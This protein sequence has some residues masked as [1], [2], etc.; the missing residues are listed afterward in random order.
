MVTV[1]EETA[2]NEVDN[3]HTEVHIDPY[4]SQHD[5][6]E[7]QI[8]VLRSHVDYNW[9]L[10]V[11]KDV[12]EAGLDSAI[13]Y[14]RFGWRELRDPSP[15]FS[16]AFY[17]EYND[18]VKR[19]NI[20]PFWHYLRYGRDEGR[21]PLPAE[22]IH[23][24]I[25]NSDEETENYP[26][27][28]ME[29][30][31]ATEAGVIRTFIDEFF[32]R[33]R[34]D[35]G[36]DEDVAD[37]YVRHGWHQLYDPSPSFKTAYYLESNPDVRE[38]GLNPLWHF[39]VAGK[40]EGRYPINPGGPK[41]EKLIAL[42]SLPD[43]ITMWQRP[44]FDGA[45]L[46][47]SVIVSSILSILDNDHRKL[48]VSV[49]HDDFQCVSGGVQLC[50]ATELDLSAANNVAHL[51]IRPRQPLPILAAKGEDPL[52]VVKLNGTDI[53]ICRMSAISETVQ[54]LAP[55]LDRCRVIIHHMLGNSP[56]ALADLC[57]A[58]GSATASV[59]IHDFFTLC[60]NF[61]L[62]RNDIT[63][64]NAPPVDSNACAICKY[65]DER[66]SHISRMAAFFGSVDVD[67]LSPSQPA[68]DFWMENTNLRYSRLE[69][70]PHFQLDW[71]EQDSMQQ[72]EKSFFSIGFVGYPSDYKGWP[73]FEK[74]VTT[75]GGDSTY[76]FYYFGV[77][78]VS[79]QHLENV[80]VHVTP[81]EP[82][83]MVESLRKNE[84][85][86]VIHWANCFETFSFSTYEA[87]AA[88]AFVITNAIS[89]N[90]ASVVAT[91]ERGVVLSSEDE[92][93]TYL[94]SN[95]FAEL[96]CRKRNNQR[97]SSPVLTKS[98]LFFDSNEFKGW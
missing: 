41:L 14:C 69:T 51:H 67:V 96:V 59:W 25:I 10:S 47:S 77:A 34:Y 80:A 95:S 93:I 54:R 74:V 42:K 70:I 53:G 37:H 82:L 24:V 9:Y 7:E 36:V 17:L 23:S 43:T 5:D 3:G 8:F 15:L 1:W 71:V 94:Q 89:G 50:V 79:L 28:R 76:R 44:P 65:G 85:D 83:A 33:Q 21:A 73:T 72:E 57:Q 90:V 97:N 6:L 88:S 49:S 92:L 91:T 35:I 27:E 45:Y 62:Q 48:I 11:Y 56:E 84:I 38:A 68:L 31:S 58:T 39:V 30:A 60:P 22:L 13:H 29:D 46:P 52:V 16:T 12:A 87:F 4:D 40:N 66:I 19:A 86:V 26:D 81:E 78:S 55:K 98:K 61:V 2:E 20:N 18:D 63:F 32:Y 64:C 75:L